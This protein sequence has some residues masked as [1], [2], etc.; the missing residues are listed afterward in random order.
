MFR[1]EVEQEIKLLA[2]QTAQEE[3]EKTSKMEQAVWTEN[4]NRL[5]SRKT[6]KARRSSFRDELEQEIKDLA[7]QAAKEHAEKRIKMEQDIVTAR[8][9][10]LR[11]LVTT[12]P[13]PLSFL[14]ELEQEIRDL[15]RQFNRD[16]REQESCDRKWNVRL[17]ERS[18]DTH[19]S[20]FQ[21]DDALI[22]MTNRFE[23]MTI[24]KKS[25]SDTKLEDLIP[26]KRM[27]FSAY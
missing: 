12:T 5:K 19:V 13:R 24:S 25:K 15:A 4:A 3:A 23:K 20:T 17:K 27:R 11:A 7:K 8:E 18:P 10:R 6:V 1:D 22:R 14:D 2:M 9:N 21:F 16:L 26:T